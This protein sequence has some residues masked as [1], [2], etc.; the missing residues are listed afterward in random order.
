M[1]KIHSLPLRD[2]F[3]SSWYSFPSM[4]SVHQRDPSGPGRATVFLVAQGRAKPQV[5]SGPGHCRE[6]SSGSREVRQ[7][8]QRPPAA[9]GRSLGKPSQPWALG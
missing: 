8:R 2:I 1:F 4:I 9:C 7:G 6:L 5:R 3:S